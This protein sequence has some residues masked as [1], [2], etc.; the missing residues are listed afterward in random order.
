MKTEK[1]AITGSLLSLSKATV[2][3]NKDEVSYCLRHML[4]AYGKNPMIFDMEVESKILLDARANGGIPGCKNNKNEAKYDSWN[5]QNLIA[6]G[7]WLATA[8]DLVVGIAFNDGLAHMTTVE[9][10]ERAK[11]AV[12]GSKVEADNPTLHRLINSILRTAGFNC[13]TFYIK[14]LKKQARCWRLN[15][16][17]DSLDNCIMRMESKLN[18]ELKLW[19]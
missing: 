12:E 14:R 11:D 6:A 13:N 9:I 17:A 16:P 4:M 2:G 1:T 19:E 10:V 8:R 15:N 5:I 18:E 3:M 7:F